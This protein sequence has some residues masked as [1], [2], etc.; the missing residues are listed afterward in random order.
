MNTSQT[1][2]KGCATVPRRPQAPCTAGGGPAQHP[3]LGSSN[4]HL[5]LLLALW[6]LWLANARESPAPGLLGDPGL[7]PG[8]RQLLP[9]ALASGRG[10]HSLC[11]HHSSEKGDLEWMSGTRQGHR[12]IPGGTSCAGCGSCP[13]GCPGRGGAPAL[14]LSSVGPGLVGGGFYCRSPGGL[15][16]LAGRQQAPP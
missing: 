8:A 5:S 13:G 2:R 9:V 14:T 6:A 10:G 12:H 15:C 4:P 16:G 1:P 7:E 3:R 11:L